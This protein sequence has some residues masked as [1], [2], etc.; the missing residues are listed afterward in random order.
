VGASGD[1]AVDLA[2]MEAVASTL[3]SGVDRLDLL[4]ES[5][6][7]MP[8]AGELSGHMAGV[9][10]NFTRSVGDL[11]IGVLTAVDQVAAS[12]AEYVEADDSSRR[13]FV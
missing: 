7:G 9:L 3:R 2:A 1:F 6:P 12:A 8:D 13:G 4:A 5:A 11:M 10:G